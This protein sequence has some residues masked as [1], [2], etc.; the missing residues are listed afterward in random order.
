[1]CTIIM[2]IM[3]LKRE[4][5]CKLLSSICKF[6]HEDFWARIMIFGHQSHIECVTD[7]QMRV[8]ANC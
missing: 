6:E 5:V 8:C 3:I 7:V 4:F 1:M 2:N